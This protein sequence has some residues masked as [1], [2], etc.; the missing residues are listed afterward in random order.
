MW[1]QPNVCFDCYII[2][3][4]IEILLGFSI[5][6]LLVF[7]II[8]IYTSKILIGKPEGIIFNYYLNQIITAP[9]LAN[10]IFNFAW[11]IF[12]LLTIWKFRILLEI[13]CYSR[14]F[15]S[16]CPHQNLLKT[17]KN[18][19]SG[20][21]WQCWSLVPFSVC[22]LFSYILSQHLGF[23]SRQLL[24]STIKIFNN[25]KWW[26]MAPKWEMWKGV[27]CT[28]CDTLNKTWSMSDFFLFIFFST[29]IL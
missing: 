23:I 24:Y 27:R 12:F 5:S 14:K 25:I 16:T 10:R 8:Q 7:Q 9:S 18:T 15:S 28:C 19:G 6:L 2:G 20:C 26:W 1:R 17:L 29:M 22:W 21:S 3:H 13:F 4:C 11:I